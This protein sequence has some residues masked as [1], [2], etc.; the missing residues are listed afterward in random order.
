MDDILMMYFASV[1]FQHKVWKIYLLNTQSRT[2][3]KIQKVQIEY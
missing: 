2:K 3:E 1:L